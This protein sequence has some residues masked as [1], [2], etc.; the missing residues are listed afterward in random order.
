MR[1]TGYLEMN[2]V[3]GQS[4]ILLNQ[5]LLTRRRLKRLLQ[6]LTL[7][8]RGYIS[9][10]LK[11]AETSIDPLTDLPLEVTEMITRHFDIQDIVRYRRVSRSWQQRL[12]DTRLLGQVISKCIPPRR[13]RRS[14]HLNLQ[15][16][17]SSQI[18]S[19][20]KRLI[21]VKFVDELLYTIYHFHKGLV[22]QQWFH[23][24]GASVTSCIECRDLF[25]QYS[26]TSG[27]L[28]AI[29]CEDSRRGHCIVV[30]SFQLDIRHTTEEVYKTDHNDHL[31]YVRCSTRLLVAISRGGF[32]YIWDHV[33]HLRLAE[34]T[35]E[36]ADV[37]AIDVSE[38]SVAVVTVDREAVN[39]FV[40]VWTADSL[41]RVPGGIRF[42]VYESFMV[43]PPRVTS[44]I[45]QGVDTPENEG[46]LIENEGTSVVYFYRYKASVRATRYDS[47]GQVLDDY[48]MGDMHPEII[49]I[50]DNMI[51]RQIGGHYL[52][53]SFK[54]SAN[55]ICFVFFDPQVFKLWFTEHATSGVTLSPKS[56]LLQGDTAYLT[57]CRKFLDEEDELDSPMMSELMAAR[58]D[59]AS[60]IP[61]LL[62]HHFSE[63]DTLVL[64]DEHMVIYVQWGAY[65]V[66][67]FQRPREKK[68]NLKC[69]ETFHTLSPRIRS[70]EE[71]REP[72]P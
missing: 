45:I 66:C 10:F 65:M 64:G 21:I 49:F 58:I 53:W 9:S 71:I 24:H 51:Q 23:H 48:R 19:D 55:R 46:I 11:A 63:E 6:K 29:S 32:V 15:H 57:V 1:C 31:D 39:T 60:L 17:N 40:T 47:T 70:E 2:N 5:Q 68:P 38:A 42:N 3:S 52:I 41:Q 33:Q 36:Y 8:Q 61:M 13:S 62:G 44:H 43:G 22:Q 18:P 16:N 50:A 26:Y 14:G 35:L 59:E 56:V 67:S 4:W 34:L 7:S 27:K 20:E 25:Y 12:T 28:A 37:T 30:T 72:D 69:E 54:N